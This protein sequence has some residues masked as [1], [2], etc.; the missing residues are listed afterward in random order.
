MLMLRDMFPQSGHTAKETK[1]GGASP[2]YQPAPP[3]C[4]VH[5]LL[6]EANQPLP[7]VAARLSGPKELHYMIC[8]CLNHFLM[9]GTARGLKNSSRVCE[10]TDCEK[11][12]VLYCTIRKEHHEA[13]C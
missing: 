13:N 4:P 5:C 3:Q 2:K 10:N 9:S 1:W 11:T 7:T 12:I 8:D 6:E